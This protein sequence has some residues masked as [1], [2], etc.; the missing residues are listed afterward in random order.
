M[1]NENEN[2]EE[3]L[4]PYLEGVLNPKER[5]EVDE[6]INSDGNL[7]REMSELREIILELR[8]GFASGMKAPQEELS[9]EEVVELGANTGTVDSMPGTSQQKARLFCSDAALEEYSLLRA[10]Q[11]EMARTTLD[12]ENVPEMP[13]AILKEFQALKAVPGRK[14][15]PFD[16]ASLSPIPLWRRAS[17][18]LDRIDPKPL[19][20]SAAALMMLSLGVHFYNKS[21]GPAGA[22]DQGQE[23]GYNFADQKRDAGKSATP[24]VSGTPT[25]ASRDSSGVA[26]FT[27]DDRGLLKE[28]AEKLMTN[29]VRYTVTKDRILVAE[30]DVEEARGILWAEDGKVVAMA[31]EEKAVKRMAQPGGEGAADPGGLAA[32][33]GAQSPNY[34]VSSAAPS[35]A[36]EEATVINVDE[37]LAAPRATAD[38]V[39]IYDSRPSRADAPSKPVAPR[40]SEIPAMQRPSAPVRAAK[41]ARDPGAELDQG[42]R[43]A[44]SGKT[45]SSADTGYANSSADTPPRPTDVQLA[46]S[47]A[48][49]S[50]PGGN[51][52]SPPEPTV[53]EPGSSTAAAP[54]SDERRRKLKELALGDDE[55]SAGKNEGDYSVGRNA[56]EQTTP[57]SS[58]PGQAQST[59]SL[60]RAR[61]ASAPPAFPASAPVPNVITAGTPPTA[62]DKADGRMAR[63]ETSRQTVAQRHGVELSF[64]SNDGKVSVYVRPKKT[65]TKAEQDALRK[66]LRK[67]LGLSDSDTI[68]LR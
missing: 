15:L 25:L 42:L 3:K 63:M 22:G 5:R 18:F 53:V 47:T 52:A 65:L 44:S 30:K 17:S 56:R 54:M 45:T 2:I 19:M 57:E 9:V 20:A 1:K 59:V 8:Q 62:E 66:A 7:A 46:R 58:A 49:R 38:D 60:E 10:L 16:K 26:V 43:G 35:T 24:A 27:S 33:D 67:E 68:I 29:K 14:V 55:A 31:K 32:D 23:I 51:V 6:A 40:P 37:A 39:K 13:Q 36:A 64:E 41:S 4:I 28:Q 11:E 12:R 34:Y 48:P 50:S 21:P 61:V